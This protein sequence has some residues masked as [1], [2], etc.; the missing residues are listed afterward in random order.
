MS[1]ILTDLLT[2]RAA[3]VTGLGVVATIGKLTDHQLYV[4][5]IVA[6]VALVCWTAETIW[7]QRK[8]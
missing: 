1:P 3:T 5:G 6:C 4:C 7:G 2:K 8:P